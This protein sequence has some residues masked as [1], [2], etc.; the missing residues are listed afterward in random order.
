MAVPLIHGEKI[1]CYFLLSENWKYNHNN[2]T[3]IE[4]AKQDFFNILT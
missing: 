1:M 3:L 4:L 2:K